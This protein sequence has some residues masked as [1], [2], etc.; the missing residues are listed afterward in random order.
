MAVL[1]RIMWVGILL[2]LAHGL[3][4][5]SLNYSPYPLKVAFKSCKLV[6]TMSLGACFTGRKHTGGCSLFCSLPR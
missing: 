5:T 2:A 1:V 6:P 4:N 3:G